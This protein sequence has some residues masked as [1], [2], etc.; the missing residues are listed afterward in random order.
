MNGW[1]CFMIQT[2]FHLLSEYLA[3]LP[4]IQLGRH[5]CARQLARIHF[6]VNLIDVHWFYRHQGYWQGTTEL[7]N[8]AITIII[9][10]SFHYTV[11]KIS[12]LQ[13]YRMTSYCQLYCLKTANSLQAHNWSSYTYR[14]WH[15]SSYTTSVILECLICDK[16]LL[17]ATWILVYVENILSLL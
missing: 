9:M 4:S 15:L 14:S 17:M 3:S 16:L 6:A 11:C 10:P 2:W 13:L 5:V 7:D 1:H 8:T 12:M